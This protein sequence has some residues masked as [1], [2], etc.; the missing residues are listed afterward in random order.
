MGWL[1][2]KFDNYIKKT[3]NEE[4]SNSEFTQVSDPLLSAMINK[5]QIT[6]SQAKSIPAVAACLDK[7]SNAIAMLPIKLYKQE[8]NKDGK[9]K[10]LK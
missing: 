3:A 10:K 2:S 1:K 6:A 5:T 4:R 8:K 9:R 7:I